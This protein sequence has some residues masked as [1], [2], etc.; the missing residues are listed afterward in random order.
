MILEPSLQELG[1][2]QRA[3]LIKQVRQWGDLNTDAILD[4]NCKIFSIPSINGIVGYRIEDRCAI[5]FGEPLAPAAEQGN[6][7]QAFEEFC[8]QQ[9]LNIVYAIISENFTNS[10]PQFKKRITIQYGNK[11]ILDSNHNP[12]HGSGPKATLVRKKVKHAIN[13]GVMINEYIHHDEALEKAMAELGQAWSNSRYGPQVYIAHHSFFKDREGKR[14]FYAMQKEQI[15]GFLILNALHSSN[16]W[17]LNNVI[18]SADA[19]AGTSELL[20]TT[21]L[22][23]LEEEKSNKVFIGPVTT[24]QNPEIKGASAIYSWLIRIG[25]KVA[26]KI[27]RLEGQRIFW[28]KFQPKQE[29]SYVMLDKINFRTVRALLKAMN[30]KI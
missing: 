1:Q 21:A 29:P 10:L 6:L 11:L 12:L 8:K 3:M 27:F 7:T 25:F 16:G 13:D 23:T 17:L 30:V 26:K 18:I 19:P 15:R 5:V 9:G 22:K 20:I 24:M 28:E 14:W 2:D 4:S